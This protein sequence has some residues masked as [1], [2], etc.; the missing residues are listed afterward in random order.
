MELNGKDIIAHVFCGVKKQFPPSTD[1]FRMTM[2]GISNI[3]GIKPV[4][5]GGTPAIPST[6][7]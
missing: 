3:S 6:K 4:P 2:A 1:G 5:A 7:S